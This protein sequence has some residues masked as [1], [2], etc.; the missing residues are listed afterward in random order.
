VSRYPGYHFIGCF[1]AAMIACGGG[2]SAKKSAP[3]PAITSFN[4]TAP[5]VTKGDSTTLTAIFQNGTGVIDHGVGT[6]QSGIAVSSGILSTSTIFGL[7]VTTTDGVA[8]T[9]SAQIIVTPWRKL[10]NLA[11]VGRQKYE[12]HPKPAV[13]G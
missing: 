6:V 3:A 13:L 4:A 9:S 5:M 10:P 7:T 12:Q 11:S 2:G 8:V 1:L